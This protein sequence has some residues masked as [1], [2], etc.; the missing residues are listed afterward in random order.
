MSIKF[1]EG[2]NS[3]NLTM[4]NEGESKSLYYSFKL[5]LLPQ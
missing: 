1:Q 4:T 2:V 3:Q 5:L